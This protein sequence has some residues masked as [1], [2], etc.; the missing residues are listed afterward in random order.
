MNRM[1]PGLFWVLA[2]LGTPQALL[3]ASILSNERLVWWGTG[4]A[5]PLWLF[6]VTQYYEGRSR[7][8]LQVGYV[9]PIVLFAVGY[10]E[11][12]MPQRPE[13]Q[14]ALALMRLNRPEPTN[15]SDVPTPKLTPAG[16]DRAL[17]R[18]T[19]LLT[20]TFFYL[21]GCA[22][23]GLFMGTPVLVYAIAGAATV[24]SVRREEV[25]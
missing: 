5:Y 8:M 17:T 4:A 10:A 21:A 9:V 20:T 14:R 25:E 12:S 16:G 6:G 22:V 19:W 15:R 24:L 11:S 3:A 1:L 23:V 2:L 18:G 13:T 7:R